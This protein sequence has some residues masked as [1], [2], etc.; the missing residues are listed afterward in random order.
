MV[1]ENLGRMHRGGKKEELAKLLSVVSE[2][3][4]HQV[5]ASGEEE[6]CW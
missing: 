1:V 6:E 3:C 4:I 5:L 2:E